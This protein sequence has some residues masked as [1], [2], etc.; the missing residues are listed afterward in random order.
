MFD[1]I[2]QV[3]H[4]TVSKTMVGKTLLEIVVRHACIIILPSRPYLAVRR[5]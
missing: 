4:W 3:K 1:V 5:T 2:D